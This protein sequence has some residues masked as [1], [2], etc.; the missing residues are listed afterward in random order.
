MAITC[1][2][3][4]AALQAGLLP[5]QERREGHFTKVSGRLNAFRR[6]ALFLIP[7]RKNNLT[8][9]AR[10]RSVH[11]SSHSNLLVQ[12]RACCVENERKVFNLAVLFALQARFCP[13][14][15]T[16]G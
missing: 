7:I 2:T 11:I 1:P 3:T 10:L 4:E 8:A 6:P 14:K 9:L 13:Q 15:L 12:K 5:A 16:R